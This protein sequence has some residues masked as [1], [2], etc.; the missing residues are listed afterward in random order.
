MAPNLQLHRFLP[1]NDAENTCVLSFLFEDPQ[2]LYSIEVSQGCEMEDVSV[3]YSDRVRMVFCHYTERS[4][5]FRFNGIDWFVY[6][7]RSS[8]DFIRL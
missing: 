7:S 3:F 6:T 2:D 1:L 4:N 5:F 8:A